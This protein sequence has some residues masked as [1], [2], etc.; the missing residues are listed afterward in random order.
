MPD[1]RP[2]TSEE[3]ELT[4]KAKALASPLRWRILRLCLHE[5]R[6]NR[7]LAAALGRNPGSMLHHV[8]ALVEVG[9]LEPLQPRAGTRGAREIPYRATGLTWHGSEAPLVGP[10]LVQTFLDEI[11]GVHP[12]DL[13]VSRL[14]VRLTPEA[15]REAIER[16]A[17]LLE[18]L[19]SKDDPAGEPASYFIAA[20]PDIQQRR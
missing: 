20:H 14:G 3:S 17:A 1:P 19:R 13:H 5:P 15:E 7:E 4:A 11:A 9:F 8:R 12:S 6:T 2:D 18:W 10:V 16:V